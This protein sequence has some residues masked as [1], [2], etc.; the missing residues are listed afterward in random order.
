[1]TSAKGA[2]RKG[3]D[4]RT[5]PEQAPIAVEAGGGPP[6]HGEDGDERRGSVVTASKPL[7]M[8]LAAERGST[9]DGV[10][11]GGPSTPT[12]TDDK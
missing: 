7:A 4:V 1:M 11:I 2:E 5:K 8:Q 10:A 6:M 3:M 9:G 12:M